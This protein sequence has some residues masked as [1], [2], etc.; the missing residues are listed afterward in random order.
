[1]ANFELVRKKMAELEEKDKLRNWQSP[2]DGDEIM[3]LFKLTPGREIGI[4]K[5]ALKDAILDGEVANDYNE[6]KTFLEN[7]FKLLQSK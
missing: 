2:I 5:N 3:K 7:K 6:A 4:L 1:L